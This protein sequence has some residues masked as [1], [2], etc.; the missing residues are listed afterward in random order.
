[1]FGPVRYVTEPVDLTRM[2]PVSLASSG[3]RR[4][5]S[6]LEVFEI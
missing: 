6:G 3:R 2:T 4:V 5:G 1:M